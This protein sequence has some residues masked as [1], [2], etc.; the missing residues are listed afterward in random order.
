[1]VSDTIPIQ[2]NYGD[3]LT[4][5]NDN[6]FDIKA[7]N[8]EEVV[9]YDPDS[10]SYLIYEKIGEEY[11]RTPISM[12]FEE[13][14]DYRSKQE[15]RRYF[16]LLGGVGEEYKS[17]TRGIPDPISKIDI[18][19]D[20]VDRLFGGT[21]V[22]IK[23]Q[24]NIDLTFLPVD[25]T[26]N[27][28]PNIPIQS[29]R[30]Y[31]F[32]I[33]PVIQMNVDGG[34]GEKLNLG[35]NYNTQATFDFDRKIKLA[36]DSEEFSED[37]IIKK[38]E[39]G[40]VSLP[41]RSTLI[42]GAQ[43][44][45]GFK[46][47][48]QFGNLRLTGIA[49]QQKSSQEQLT[50]QN[51]S[52]VQPFEIRPDEYDENRHFFISHYHR[53]HFEQALS[54]LP[55]I[56]SR[57]TIN[58][59][60][61]WISDDRA[62]FQSNQRQVV[63][64]ADLGV[65]EEE[66]LLNTTTTITNDFNYFDLNNDVLPVNQAN[67]I[68]EEL[69]EDLEARSN[70]SLLL[71]RYGLA[72]DRG[73]FE[74]F[75]GRL[76][77]PGEFD[78]N[79]DLGVLSLNVRLKPNQS[80]AVAY[81][82]YY[83]PKCDTL[84]KVGELTRSTQFAA[85]D[86]TGEVKTEPRIY[87]KMLKSQCQSVN[88]PTWDLMMKNVYA[89]RTN[90]LNVEDFKFDI[91]YEDDEG[92]GSLKKYIPGLENVPLLNAFNLDRLNS[93]NDPQP[94][95][96]FDFVPGITV[97]PR[98]GAIIFPILEPFGE[99]LEQVLGN[100]LLAEKYAFTELY[101]ESLIDARETLEKNK[102]IMRGEFKSN[103]SAQQSLGAWNIP[104]GS[105]TVRAGSQILVEGSDYEVNYATGQ[106][107]IINKAYEEQG[108]PIDIQ[109]EDNSVFSFQQKT[110]LGLRADYALSKNANI[111]AT[112][113]RL[114]ERPFTQKV[115]IGD[116]P[117]NN[118]IFG[119]DFDYS[120]ESAWVTKMVDKLPFYSTNE[121]SNVI[122]TA[123]AAALKPG[124]S[125]AINL[126]DEREGV[127]NIDDFEGAVSG[128]PL[129]SQLN[130]WALASTPSTEDPNEFP[131][132]GLVNNIANNANRAKLNWYVIDQAARRNSIDQDHPYTRRIN[133]DELF[134]R[135]LEPSQLPDLF[136]FDLNYFPKE[137]GPYN[138]DPP[139]GLEIIDTVT[140]ATFRTEGSR[141]NSETDRVE[142]LEPESRWAGITRYM[143][144]SD[145]QAA[146][147]EFIDFWM[148]NPYMENS[149]VGGEP[150]LEN[151]QGVIEFHLGNVSEDIINDDESFF[152]NTLPVDQFDYATRET[153]YGVT[154]IQDP[155]T[156][157][158]DIE[159]REAQDRG[160]DGIDDIEERIKHANYLEALGNPASI[161]EDPS[162]D[163]FAYFLNENVF[164]LQEP[165]TTRYKQFNNPQGNAP[166]GTQRE[167]GNPYPDKED[168]NNNYSLNKSESYHRYQIPIWNENG[169][170]NVEQAKYI[171]EQRQVGDEIWYRFQIPLDDPTATQ[172]NGINGF[173]CIQYMRIITRNFS[174]QKT[175][176]LAEFEL[177]RSQ[178]RRLPAICGPE[179]GTQEIDFSL[180]IVGR[181]ENTNKQPFGYQLP[182]G[183]I[184][185]RLFNTFSAVAQDERSISMNFKG[186]TDSCE[187]S[188]YKL[189]ELDMRFYD[190]LQMFIHAEDD[191]ETLG[192]IEDGDLAL[193]I[194]IGKD[195]TDNYYEYEI[196]LVPSNIR[197]SFLS[198]NDQVWRPE[199]FLDL[200]L[201]WF[202]ELKKQRSLDQVSPAVRYAFNGQMIGEVEDTI[203]LSHKLYMK[204]NPTLGF[205]RGIQI[206]VRNIGSGDVQESFDGE[207]WVN[208]LRAVGFEERGGVAATARLD[209]QM[210]DLGNITFAGNYNSIGWG[211]LDQQLSERSL[212]EVLEYDVATSLEL[213]KFF[214]SNWGL[215]IPFYAQY[216]KSI[217]TPKYDP[218]ALD[219][220]V[221]EAVDLA[222]VNGEDV[223]EVRN[224]ANDVTTIKTINFTNVRKE[225][226]TPSNKADKP[227][228][229]SSKGNSKDDS[230][231]DLGDKKD[232][233]KKQ[234]K[235]MPWDISN[236]S[237]S[238]S[239]TE[240][241]HRDEILEVNNLKNYRLGIDYNYSIR[242]KGIYPFKKL[243]NKK[244]LKV[245]KEINFN[246]VPSN[247]GF[248][249]DINRIINT[250]RFRLP[251][252]P[253]FEFDDRRFDWE[254]RYNLQW[255][256][257]KNLKMNFTASNVSFIDE[258]RQV[259][260]DQSLEGREWVDENGLSRT[261]DVTNDPGFVRDYWRQNLFGWGR[262][263]NYNHKLAI[264]YTLPT[265][266]ISILDWIDVTAN[267]KADYSWVAGALVQI[268]EFGNGT[269]AQ[270]SNGQD[271]NAK[272]KLN[273]D[274]FYQKFKYFK[275]IEGKTSS[276][277][278][279][280][281]TTEPKAD[282]NADPNAP[283]TGGRTKKPKDR[284]PSTIEKALVRPFLSLR[285][286]TVNYSETFESFIPG[287]TNTPQLFGLS[288]K[289]SSP[290]WKYVLGHQYDLDPN[291]TS[292]FLYQSAEKG[293]INPSINFNEQ[294]MQTERQNFN[295]TIDLEPWKDLNVKVDFKKTYT[296][297]RTEHFQNKSLDFDNPNFQQFAGNDIG[298]FEVTYWNIATMFGNNTFERDS[299]LG[300]LLFENFSDY[301]T[302]I[303]QIQPNYT[304]AG[305]HSV[306]GTEYAQGYGQLSS[307][308]IVPA[309]LAAYGGQDPNDADLDL[310]S[311]VKKHT[312]IPKP[313]WSISYD[314]L[315]KLNI[316]KDIIS[317][318]TIEHAYKSSLRVNQ[319]R[320]DPDYNFNESPINN[321]GFS[322][323]ETSVN[324]NYYSR[325]NLDAIVIMEDFSPLIGFTLLTTTDFELSA[326]Y[327]KSRQ[328]NL[329][330]VTSSLEERLTEGIEAGI[331]YVFKNV[332]LFGNK[333]RERSRSKRLDAIDKISDGIRIG[334]N[335]DENEDAE[336][337][338]EDGDDKG[339]ND[340]RGK[341]LIFKFDFSINDQ[342]SWIHR[343]DLEGEPTRGQ[344]TI[345][346]LPS[347]E[348]EVNK[349]LSLRSF[350]DY[351]RTNPYTGNSFRRT[352]LKVG[353]TMRFKLN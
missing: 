137:R 252:D 95:G 232:K 247:F 346:F 74:S 171:K 268:D 351:N 89:L 229:G 165:L 29:Q 132:A 191:I 79:T 258:L 292:N 238:Y 274:K 251:D 159:R 156:N 339:V 13:Y 261:N 23:P 108:I 341:E 299:T 6:P 182:T 59:I 253:I 39:A 227:P 195:W 9:E 83:T 329:S 223:Q 283:D 84:Y 188:M 99:G 218:Y 231:V 24:G 37:D 31:N 340:N 287:F 246:P 207:V 302:V 142:L 197:D 92:D 310:E 245:I 298:S 3:F 211:A 115:N 322:N 107:N 240:T 311:T 185:E 97:I 288:D 349:Y 57:F 102:F 213:G 209:V 143:N 164:D 149:A 295:A 78:F 352:N 133:Q 248:S 304:G 146:N 86:S 303:S 52:I 117:I 323:P 32:D 294:L 158:F 180:D 263:I 145:F 202:T 120:K 183:I 317:N 330:V 168:L 72:R 270:I 54:N 153:V 212:D 12:T 155:A 173:R 285:K 327:H 177:V 219:L 179:A 239:Y 272:L 17:K 22:T 273:I 306:D 87:L 193:F 34:I 194:K 265:K 224:R 8:I 135:D 342:I 309:F 170:I 289:W 221:D 210:A 277:G 21:G 16:E 234:R 4:D 337:A 109:F 293:W 144:N 208:E 33:D 47:E 266:N 41:L 205:V 160:F 241:D 151:E 175:F 250:R 233:E 262:N 199:N 222:L 315:S 331:G 44:L 100:S 320:T 125:K 328:L 313:N 319:F 113:L 172:V 257:M 190:R 150:H 242:S 206:G 225:R 45:F 353:I 220:T 152:E 69:S 81:D 93:I 104:Q 174:T 67:D 314:G 300:S 280:G 134:V 259:G 316:F 103:Q 58:N 350:V 312:Y 343:F 256:L 50:I 138:F 90:Q 296:K 157:S 297:S 126:P 128:L 276:S 140:G 124:H 278:R 75:K 68:Y 284:K 348:Y 269:G 101:D 60:E 129:S 267:Y 167:R 61:V 326:R 2:D 264:N 301:R 55:Y 105:V 321:P 260:V 325:I 347:V 51:G 249:S 18:Q 88:L 111:G 230:T 65:G 255:D 235:P 141:F 82:Y 187:V 53:E 76:L 186:L 198:V 48:L 106:V 49:S 215:R 176:R 169:E 77:S 123:E 25:F 14:L 139:D 286:I 98:S 217:S 130:R 7:G 308:V 236:F 91:F 148:L 196:P 334:G 279:R 184:Q 307:D 40:N 244:S 136:T 275:K 62:D 166:D 110:V 243:I 131:E 161:L 336:D 112:Y 42:Q 344:R 305:G 38:I 96:I 200:N 116:D 154:T 345:K 338:A 332:N 10:D 5:P 80:L 35:F 271:R 46:T 216:A 318:F 114:F 73:D 291:N 162:A 94:D 122:F 178:W 85:A 163:N 204:G 127:V 290:G 281:R 1:M 228:K 201:D 333:K 30:R 36:Y 20:L 254:R 118:R 26:N 28:N 324:G 282:P 70:E 66:V 71:S 189:T 27:E 192:E 11:Y 15:E 119:V 335:S 226:S 56:D 63:S 64:I 19:G 121:V 43:T 214:P 181:E 147:Y 203:P 237:L